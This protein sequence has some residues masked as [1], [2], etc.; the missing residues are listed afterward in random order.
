MR[1]LVRLQ[2]R[3]YAAVL[4]A[5]KIVNNLLLGRLAVF[6]SQDWPGFQAG[7]QAYAQHTLT[8]KKLRGFICNKQLETGSCFSRG[9]AFTVDNF[10][11]GRGRTRHQLASVYM[12]WF[13]FGVVCYWVRLLWAGFICS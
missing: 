12:A 2:P 1:Q 7:Q 6:I 8:V 4:A 11:P 5:S 3:R 9:K 13:R 10:F